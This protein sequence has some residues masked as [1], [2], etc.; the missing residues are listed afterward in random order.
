MLSTFC[1]RVLSHETPDAAPTVTS[2][3]NQS[4]K[5][6]EYLRRAERVMPGGVSSNIRLL[7]RPGPLVLARGRGPVLED[8]DGR[9]Y[10]DYMCGM[11][12]VILGHGDARVARAISA[13]VEDGLTLPRRTRWR[14]RWRSA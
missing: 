3:M 7:E 2:A 1:D 9:T 14:S 6:S 10:I 4:G 12:P 11:G 8:V 5:S 13:V